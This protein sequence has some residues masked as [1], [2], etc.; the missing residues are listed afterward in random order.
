MLIFLY[1]QLKIFDKDTLHSCRK[2][3]ILYSEWYPDHAKSKYEHYSS[4]TN[5]QSRISKAKNQI[6]K[7]LTLTNC[8]IYWVYQVYWNSCRPSRGAYHSLGIDLKNPDPLC[9]QIVADIKSRIDSGQLRVDDQIG[10]QQEL[11]LRYGGS[12]NTVKKA[13]ADLITEGVLYSRV[14]K[15]TYVASKPYIESFFKE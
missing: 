8:F 9:R 6:K 15:G 13:L 14:G 4:N 1:M 5:F 3:H 2:I 11:A 10:S 12:L 7:G